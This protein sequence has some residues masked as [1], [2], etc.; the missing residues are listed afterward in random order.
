MKVHD[1]TPED[2]FA[3]RSALITGMWLG[4]LLVLSGIEQPMGPRQ[5]QVD[6][7]AMTLSIA[8]SWPMIFCLELLFLAFVR[9]RWDQA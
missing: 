5:G 7:L 2:R 8:V 6:V 9:K 1:P 4:V 3:Y